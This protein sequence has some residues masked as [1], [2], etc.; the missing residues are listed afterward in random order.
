MFC[1]VTGS[2]ALGERLDPES[3]R[4]V[5]SRY[6]DAMR[7]AIERHGGTV[8]KYIGD[9][10][11][12]VFG[13]PP[14][15]RGRRAPRP[16]A[17]P[18]TCAR[19]SSALNKEL[20]RDR[21][22]TIAVRIG[23]NT[24][25]VV[26]G[27]PTAGQALV[28]GDAVN[29]AARLEEHAAPG[30]I[31]LGEATHRLVRDAVEAEPVEPLVLKGKVRAGSGVARSSGVRD[32]ASAVPRRLDSPMVGRER[33]ARPAPQAFEAA[34]EDSACQLFTILGSAGV[35]KSRLVEE[36]LS[37]VGER[38][39]VLRGRCL[40]YGEGITYFPVVE[41]IKEAAGLADFDL[42]EVVEA[43]VCAVLEG[44]EHQE[45]VCR[46]VAQ[47]IGVAESAARRGDLLGDPPVLRGRGARPSAGAGV[48]RRPL[49]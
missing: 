20:E 48:R 19:G 22:V 27:D 39:T 8:E 15:P 38:A 47:L 44:D 12:A 42:P 40:P 45:I 23:V 34:V 41:A 37:G 6:F 46:H 14:A 24:G 2:T 16:C 5:Q 11:M 30:E 49:G 4:D 32:V 28:T 31:L 1:D 43:K 25:E 9:A 36:F 35:G 21:G 26:A 18:S 10:V 3:L 13:I 29:V 33:P 17:P 7:E